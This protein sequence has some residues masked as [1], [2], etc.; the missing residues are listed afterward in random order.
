MEAV[1]ALEETELELRLYGV[2]K[3]AR[4]SRAEPDPSFIHRELRRAGVTLELLHLEYLEE[5]PGGLGRIH[6]ACVTTT[7]LG[8][9]VVQKPK[10]TCL[11]PSPFALKERFFK[12]LDHAVRRG[13]LTDDCCVE[14]A[15]GR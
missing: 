5:H 8:N 4:A 10:R 7:N 12:P 13:G 9:A 2:P 11:M 1:D 15:R 3:S 14:H 6:S